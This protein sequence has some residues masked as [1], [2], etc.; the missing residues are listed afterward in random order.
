MR[1]AYVD[2]G[3]GQVHLRE[4]GS[5]PPVLLLHKTPTSSLTYARV[6]P[7]VAAAGYRAIAMDTPGY[8]QSDRPAEAPTE[9]AFY[10]DVVRDVL[11]ALAVEQVRLVGF[12][13]GAKIA[14][15]TAASHPSRVCSLVLSGISINDDAAQKEAY[16]TFIQSLGHM[17][18]S[19]DLDVHGA[20]LEEYPL[21][22]FRDIVRGDGEQYLLELISYLQSARNYWWGYKASE[23]YGGADR[24]AFVR[25]PLLLLNPVD[26]LSYVVDK[27]RLAAERVPGARYVEIP[28]T[29]DVLLEDPEGW[30]TP[31]TAF[32]RDADAGLLPPA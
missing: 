20:F 19:I 29:T 12:Y 21:S 18:F 6:L 13:T 24:L 2:T 26:G 22:W 30:T 7:L 3:Y 25:C 11:D 8:G 10:A 16:T 31:V 15:E 9:M 23:G 1:C 32:L 17:R 28:G 4:A 14:L 5:G 27:T